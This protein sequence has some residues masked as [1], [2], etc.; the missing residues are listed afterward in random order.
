MVFTNEQRIFMIGQLFI[1]F[2]TY[3]DIFNNEYPDYPQKN[4]KS[5]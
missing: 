3:P 2:V 4:K 5:D 1:C